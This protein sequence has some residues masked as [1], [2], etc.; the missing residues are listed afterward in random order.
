[1]SWFKRFIELVTEDSEALKARLEAEKIPHMVEAPVIGFVKTVKANP[2]RFRCRREFPGREEVKQYTWMTREN[3]K[4]Y[5]ITDKLLGHSFV[6]TIYQGR[7]YSVYG[8]NI[9]LNMWESRYLLEQLTPVFISAVN[10]K[11]RRAQT[12]ADKVR[13][14]LQEAEL[15]RRQAWTSIYGE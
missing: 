6:V 14:A 7:I 15:D 8:A 12:Q 5:K 3:T 13:K 1:M 10:R 2:R 4:F 11:H 9:D